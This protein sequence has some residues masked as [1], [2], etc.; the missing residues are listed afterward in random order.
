M[1]EAGK[2]GES[3]VHTDGGIE[4]SAGKR[5]KAR[6]ACIITKRRGTGI[7]SVPGSF[8]GR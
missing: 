8:R 3:G 1:D 2:G 7:G 5:E 4:L 6:R